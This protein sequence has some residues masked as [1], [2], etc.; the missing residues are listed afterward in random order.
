MLRATLRGVPM[1]PWS[2]RQFV[3]GAGVMGLGLVTGCGR[4][5]WQAAPAKV[6]RIAYVGG[7]VR[8][9][10]LREG[11]EQYGYTE[12]Q[13]LVIDA[14]SASGESAE[15]YL[16]IAEE[17]VRLRPD[18]IVTGATPQTQAAKQVTSSIP[19]VFV[20]VSDPVG[21]GFVASLARPGG[22]VT[23]QSDLFAG[24]SGKRLELLKETVPSL[25]RVAV[26]WNPTNPATALE[27]ATAQD[28][29]RALGL[30]LLPVTVHSPDDF[31][32]AF[33][34]ASRERPD[35]LLTL[36]DG[37]FAVSN[38]PQIVQ[39]VV[40]SRLPTMYYSRDGVEAGMLM[41][42]GPNFDSLYRRAA[43]YVDRILKGTSPADLPVEQPREIDFVINLKTAQALGLTIPQHVLLQATEVIQ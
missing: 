39:L 42:Y 16:A 8:Y 15:R 7:A 41:A 23:G 36:T 21:L 4:L 6:P 11:L 13:N 17:V 14:R 26:L 28:A 35:A 37:Q 1:D 32:S 5:P 29:G 10:L 3:Q 34:A 31:V 27:W 22:N 33:E 18:V 25:G 9:P 19:I 2:R 12:G 20:S 30:E 43:Y 38:A 40:Q 24:L